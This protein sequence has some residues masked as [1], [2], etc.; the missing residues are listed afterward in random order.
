MFEPLTNENFEELLTIQKRIFPGESAE[1]NYLETLEHNP[2]RKELANWLVLYNN[3]PVGVVGLYSY[4][5]YPNTAW[6]GW[7]GVLPEERGKKFGSEIF[8]FWLETAKEKGYTEARLYTDKIENQ[9]ALGFYLHNRMTQETYR[10]SSETQEITDSTLIFSLSLTD[11][12]I[13]KWDNKFLELSE[14]LE[15]QK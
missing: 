13:E 8:D 14:Q 6:L 9:D 11:K 12:P 1:Q 3:K 5:E 7:F 4:H 10:N 2:Y 15:K